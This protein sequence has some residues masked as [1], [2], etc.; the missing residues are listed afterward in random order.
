M[1]TW[2]TLCAAIRD[3]AP[4]ETWLEHYYQ[5]DPIGLDCAR[6]VAWAYRYQRKRLAAECLAGNGHLL[7][8]YKYDGAPY[9]TCVTLAA[10]HAH[11]VETGYDATNSQ[12]ST[13]A[14]RT[15]S[16]GMANALGGRSQ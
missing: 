1:T 15:T 10:I 3:N 4:V 13:P 5:L 6:A 11:I 12:K 9:E 8:A 7:N 16:E 2:Q 14:M